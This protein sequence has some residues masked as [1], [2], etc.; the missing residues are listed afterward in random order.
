MFAL[1]TIDR[2]RILNEYHAQKLFNFLSQQFIIYQNDIIW[3]LYNEFDIIISQS[4][5]SRLFKQAKYS[6]KI[7]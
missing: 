5:I 3:F 1:D 4:M 6:R 2:L 7:T